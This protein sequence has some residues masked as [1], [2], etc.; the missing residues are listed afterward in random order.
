MTQPDE[1]RGPGR[2]RRPP[3]DPFSDDDI[4]LG[5]PAK[6]SADG[7]TGG[8]GEDAHRDG[9]ADSDGP[10]PF[11]LADDDN[12]G[13]ISKRGPAAAGGASAWS[14]EGDDEVG[15]AAAAE[16]YDQAVEA[17]PENPQRL[18]DRAKAWLAANYDALGTR[19]TLDLRAAYS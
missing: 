18:L 13:R 4:D 3:A 6:P 16:A 5:G 2:K 11:D 9:S 12:G 7:P 1:P 10:N 8:G 19:G 14:G 15:D 17:D